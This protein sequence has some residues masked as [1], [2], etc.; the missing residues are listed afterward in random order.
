MERASN[1]AVAGAGSSERER[2][3][4]E[5]RVV[6]WT[7]RREDNAAVDGEV[8]NGKECVERVLLAAE[9]EVDAAA[10]CGGGGGEFVAKATV[11]RY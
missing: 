9:R 3:A 8:S 4:T 2:R 10:W 1:A 11:K 6:V 7:A 5:R